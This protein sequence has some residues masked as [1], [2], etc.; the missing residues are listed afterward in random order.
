MEG[1]FIHTPGSTKNNGKFKGTKTIGVPGGYGEAYL[2][3]WLNGPTEG[4]TVVPKLIKK[5]K[6]DEASHQKEFEMMMKASA[7]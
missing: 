4:K 7:L 6:F 1:N 3:K 2:A 5:D